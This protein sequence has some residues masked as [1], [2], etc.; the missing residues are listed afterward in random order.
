MSAERF[1]SL[2]LASKPTDPDLKCMFRVELKKDDMKAE[3]L[4]EG[5][6]VLLSCSKTRSGG[7]GIAFRSTD[8]SPSKVGSSVI[9]VYEPLKSLFGLSLGEKVTVRKWGGVGEGIGRARLVKVVDV[10]AADNAVMP[11]VAHKLGYWVGCALG[12]LD[13]V[14]IAEGFTFDVPPR[15]PGRPR[16]YFRT[17]R[18]M[19]QEI[20]SEKQDEFDGKSDAS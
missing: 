14:F 19:V 8:T 15:V 17:R 20:V 2:R 5:D 6:A 12:M 3:A 9:K 4:E 10:S 16:G 13:S 11:E 7:V 18:Y 1:Y